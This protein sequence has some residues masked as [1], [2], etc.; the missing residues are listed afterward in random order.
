MVD[1]YVGKWYI[2]YTI[3]LKQYYNDD[4]YLFY[5]D[6]EY[7]YLG[8]DISGTKYDVARQ[9]WGGNWCMP[10]WD[11]FKEL[12][13]NCT[14]EW[15]TINGVYGIKF[16]SKINGNSIFLPAAGARVFGGFSCVGD[17]GLY[18]MSTLDIIFPTDP[19]YFF[20]QSDDPSDDSLYFD[21]VFGLSV[22]P[23]VRN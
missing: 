3:T 4:T 22:R 18:W 11:D 17:Y 13:D 16:T 15:T 19:D 23:V 2:K 1:K 6:G 8:D 14:N 9:R 12:N 7:M 20:F 21:R 10:S 5:N